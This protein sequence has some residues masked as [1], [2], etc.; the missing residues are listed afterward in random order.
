MISAMDPRVLTMTVDCGDHV[1]TFS[2]NDYIG[3]K[4]FRKG[5]F[6]RHHVSRLL[7][8]LRER[9]LLRSDA[10]LLELGGNIGTQTIYFSLS[11][12]FSHIISV[13]PDPRNFRLLRSNIA[14][15]HLEDRVTL[16]NCAA[17]D[18]DGELD[19][20][21]HRNNHGKSSAS[22]QSH[23]DVKIVVPVRRVDKILEDAAIASDQI[24]LIWMDIEGY[25]P[26]ACRSMEMLLQ[27]QVPLYLEFSP[28]FYGDKQAAAF[29][30]YLSGF[31]EDCLVFLGDEPT[32]MKVRE[33]PVDRIQFDILLFASG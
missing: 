13:E 12:S 23:T 22:R 31:Y 11:G 33:I 1:M 2:P 19:F 14:Q 16:V 10:T 5:H 21:Q 25:E 6:E 20:F 7:T 15:N 24:G 4:I 32:P 27:R 8:I 28:A 17:G 3:R 26:V 18:R 9:Q 29:V 30:Q